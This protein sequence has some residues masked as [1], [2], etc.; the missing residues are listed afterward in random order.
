MP[1]LPASRLALVDIKH[2]GSASALY[3]QHCAAAEALLAV[4][5]LFRE[6]PNAGLRV[7]KISRT[8]LNLNNLI[9]C[10]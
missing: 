6:Q 1:L 7:R 10:H 2:T 3:R 4:V 5:R 9:T 8:L